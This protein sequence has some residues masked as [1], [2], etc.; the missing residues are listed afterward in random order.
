MGKVR[1]MASGEQLR[2][3]DNRVAYGDDVTD[4][5]SV[6]SGLSSDIQNDLIKSIAQVIRDEIKSEINF[7]KFV[8][9]IAD[10]TPDISHREQM[11]VIFHY[12]TKTGI[13]ERF[14]GSEKE[15]LTV[16]LVFSAAGDTVPPMVVFPYI[17]PPREVIESM[18][19]DWFLGRSDTGWMKSDIF[20]EYIANG[21]NNWL[22][23]KQ[24]QKPVLLLVDGHRSHLTME[25]SEFC[26]NN[27]IILYSLPAN[28]THILQPA[29]VSV[30][31]PLKVEWRKVVKE[32]Q[33]REEN[34]NKQLTKATFCPLLDQILKKD[35]KSAIKNGFKKCGLYPFSPD[36]VDYTKC[37]I[38]LIESPKKSV[39][40]E[41][42]ATTEK[43]LRTYKE[44]IE[45]TGEN[46][47]NVTVGPDG[48]LVSD[49]SQDI[50]FTITDSMMNN[51]E[52]A[53]D[54]SFSLLK[55]PTS[56]NMSTPSANS[57]VV[58]SGSNTPNNRI[59]VSP[60]FRKHL[61]SPRSLSF[62]KKG[63]NKENIPNAISS[64]I[65]RRYLQEKIDEKNR[66]NVQKEERKQ[67]LEAMREEKNKKKED[68]A[69]KRAETAL[70]RIQKKKKQ[71]TKQDK[72]NYNSTQ[73]RIKC[74]GCDED[75]ISDVEEDDL[76]NIGCDKCPRPLAA[77]EILDA[78]EN[79]SD[80]EEDYRERLIC[81]LPPVDPDCLTDEDSGEE[82]N[83]T[84]NN[85]PRNI[86]LQPAEVMIQGQIM[87][88][89]TE[90][91]PSD[92]TGRT[93]RRRTYAW[94]KRDLAKNPVNWP[95]VQ[96]A[97]QDK[98]PIEWFENFLDED[99][100]SLLV[101]ESNKYAVKKNLPGDITTEDMKCFIGIL[102]VSGYSWLPRR[103]MYWEN[104]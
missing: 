80:N 16:L 72:V 2:A 96:G 27:K 6:F 95:D 20:F 21:V 93:K 44:A 10:E 42:K 34:L 63:K 98:R 49:Q 36:L 59:N 18:P 8:S 77:H 51:L 74:V 1:P 65:Y 99:V 32:W 87:V 82:D 67:R 91:E 60:C 53:S 33:N 75:L 4:A 5:N 79:V 13:E 92:S 54:F 17:R 7:A 29:D 89:D 45:D 50:E 71:K 41:E 85:L 12:L 62:T 19:L 57:L 86:L 46:I 69:K 3:L 102:L 39:S 35:M 83:V 30:F 9:V 64:T 56:R 58:R 66:K 76:K 52:L 11:S 100:I 40:R 61:Y 90:E 78:L 26:D 28:A 37:V 48:V 104:S 31:R 24:I 68:L 55:S 70:K 73:P 88:S 84:L 23:E 47:E 22:T 94:R 103:R 14:V 97:C 38:N 81:I 15:T 25:L 43:V 101:S